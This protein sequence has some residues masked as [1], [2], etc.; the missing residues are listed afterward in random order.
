MQRKKRTLI[1]G[2]FSGVLAAALVTGA[3]SSCESIQ[4]DTAPCPHGVSLRF[5]YDYNMEYANAFPRKVDCLTLL[6]YDDKGDHV[7]TRT[8]TGPELQDESFRMSLDLDEGTYRFVA[9]GGLA[10][11][12]HSFSMQTPPETT[13][14]GEL[15]VLLDAD[16]ALPVQ[17]RLHDLFWGE[18]TLRTAD[19]YREGTVEMMK[20]TNNIRIV[21]QQ[22]NGKAVN[23]KDFEFTITDDNT[24][25]ASDNE[26][27]PNSA[28]GVTYL[29]WC[30]D[31]ASAGVTDN[32]Q[33]VV[34]AYAEFSTS[35]LMTRNRPRLLI[36]RAADRKTVVDIP[37]N[38]YLLL[39]KSQLHAQMEAQEFLDRQSEWSMVF[40][41]SEHQTWLNA[42][43]M[44]NDWK[45]V[46]NNV[47][48]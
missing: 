20:N 8:V 4:E 43:I 24:L 15:R 21:L 12:E 17:E 31:Q 35:R 14:L 5:V 27:I 39:L 42:Y 36:R 48:L 33:E 9:Y 47:K 25:F 29:P 16:P 37:L 19:E 2:L 34:V 38:N 3:L 6:V 13:T 22:M 30:Q 45:V 32:A 26:L 44:I 23:P 11:D 7:A 46:L 40:F 1:S 18:L 28:G 10:C 41:L